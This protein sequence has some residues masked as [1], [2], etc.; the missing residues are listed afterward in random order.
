M[1]GK[2]KP[3]KAKAQRAPAA[4]GEAARSEYERKRDFG[5][6][7][8]P[9]PRK[10]KSGARKGAKPKPR[11]VVQ[12]HS[13]RRLHWDLR[14]EHDG[15]AAS[16]A[17]PN[18]IPMDPDQNRKAIR[19]ED[20]PLE[21]LTWEGEI[22]K[23]EYGAGTMR[24]WDSG[25]F[26]LE[27][28]SDEKVMA[29]FEGERLRG[30][31]AI[32]RAGKSDRD[33][34]I[35][36]ID[37]PEREADPFPEAVVPM[38]AKLAPLPASDEEWAVEVKWDGVRAIAYCQPGRLE[39][40]TRNLNTVTDS[41]PEVRRLSRQIGARD[42]VLD[43]E[44]VAFDE[45]G[46]PSFERLQ[47]RIHQTSDAVVRRRM[48]SHPVTY[49]IFD[50]LYLD[51]RNLMDE[52]YSARRE[53]LQGLGLEGES[54]QTPGNSVGHAEELLAAA[55]ERDLEGIVLKRL[56]SRYV[57]GKRTGAWLKVKNLGRQEFVIGGWLPGEGRRKGTLGALLLG[58]RDPDGDSSGELRYAGKV[59]TGFSEG[60]L[61]ELLE[62]LRPLARRS[63]PFGR[64]G[65]RAAHYVEPALVA[66]VSYR[67]LTADGM[68]RHGSFKGLREDK[69]AAEVEL[70]RA[71]EE[72]ASA[73]SGGGGKKSVVTVGGREL[74]LSNLGKVLYPKAGF[75]KGQV[76]DYYARVAEALLP[77]LRGRPLTMK[78]YPDGVEG[79]H[80]YEKRCPS[81]RPEWVQ[82]ARIWSESHNEDVDFCVVE[83][84]PTLIWAANL[85]DLE[86]HTSLSPAA[87]IERPTAMVFDLDPGAPAD[88]LDCAQVAI[89]IRGL[90][91][92]LGLRCYPKTSGSK[93]IQV[94]VPLNTGAG[95]EETKPFAKAVAE[96]LEAKFGDRVVSS[97][98]KRRRGGKV[99][100]DWSQNDQH[101]TTVCV[102]SLRAKERPT[103]STPV[104]WEEVEAA[105]AAGDAT[106]LLFDADAVL[107]RVAERGDL[108]APLLSEK[109]RLPE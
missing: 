26:E 50:L 18:G 55:A 28:W 46:R 87:E 81:H 88:V 93:G 4:K 79:P 65:P 38:L 12:E 105:L 85:A 96:T 35:H 73:A 86:L 109:Q 20:H 90:F 37:P 53:L 57:P 33:W 98:A 104:E 7:E 56:D 64:R 91:D 29:A 32:F 74:A 39:L 69:P 21:Y 31:Y 9:A 36:R 30:R 108:F 17:V 106:R 77:H 25:T 59:G 94:Y 83:D 97:M 48:K 40:Q 68:I 27:K 49:V 92:Q 34:M 58:Y 72:A 61:R 66:E 13:A 41:Y 95:Y 71:V 14:L 51:G 24:V 54:W 15:A 70:E 10:R 6:T 102:Y 100:I 67:E 63:S 47:Q 8:E 84:L 76:V 43:G 19:T 2:S 3:R 16:W 75:S 1:A 89:W 11:F 42:A 23:G 62:R 5:K 22:P 78:R 44:L 80:F 45:Q 107:R 99:L 103:V 60:D 52:P 82:T 101:K